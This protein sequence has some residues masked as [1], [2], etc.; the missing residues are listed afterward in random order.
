MSAGKR[1]IA[2]MLTFVMLFGMIPASAF[3]A[4]SGERLYVSN[5]GSGDGDGSEANPYDFYT[6]YQSASDGDTLFFLDDITLTSVESGRMDRNMEIYIDG[7]NHEL[8][9]A[10]QS[11]SH[12]GILDLSRGQITIC[13]LTIVGKK[14]TSQNL[15]CIYVDGADV[16]LSNVNL[17]NASMNGGGGAG[18]YINSGN[19]VL[20]GSEISNCESTGDD[21]AAIVI[22][23][24][25][26][27]SIE[28]TV[29]SDCIASDTDGSAVY[30]TGALTLA[31][32]TVIQNNDCFGV[33][34]QNS[35]NAVVSGNVL[36]TENETSNVYLQTGAT[37]DVSSP[38]TGRIGLTVEDARYYR[39]VS[40]PAPSIADTDE[41]AFVYD[42]NFYD[43]R[44][45]IY[46]GEEGLY[47][48]HHSVD[49]TYDGTDKEK[50]TDIQG[51]DINGETVSYPDETSVDEDLVLEV[52]T[53]DDLYRLP[54]E[55]VITVGGNSLTEGEDYNWDRETGIITVNQ[56]SLTGEVNISV[57]SEVWYDLKIQ[58]A[59]LNFSL[60][61]SVSGTEEMVG[62]HCSE[63]KTGTQV[64]GTVSSADSNLPIEG[65]TVTLYEDYH[66]S[67]VAGTTTTDENGFYIFRD[68][69]VNKSYVAVVSYE[70]NTRVVAS[71]QITIHITPHSGTN[72]PESVL[73]DGAM[74]QISY[75]N[76]IFIGTN[77]KQDTTLTLSSN[78][79]GHI[80]HFDT[81]GGDGVQPQDIS[82]V[83]NQT[84]FPALPETSRTG[85][86]FDG[87]YTEPIGGNLIEGGMTYEFT[88][89]VTLYAHWT[90]NGDIQYIVRHYA[91]Y[92]PD[93]VNEVASAGNVEDRRHVAAK[94][95]YLF[96]EVEYYNGVADATGMDI[97]GLILQ[98]MDETASEWWSIE[99]FHIDENQNRESLS[100]TGV[101]VNPDGSSVYNIYYDR[102][103]YTVTLPYGSA[104][105]ASSD[106]SNTVE[107]VYGTP[108]GDQVLESDVLPSLPGYDFEGWLDPDQQASEGNTLVQ[109][110]DLFKWT[111]DIKLEPVYT[112]R[113]D[114]EV[115]VHYLMQDLERGEDGRF[116]VKGT[117]T[118][119]DDSKAEFYTSDGTKIENYMITGTTDQDKIVAPA[120]VEGFHFV[121]YTTLQQGR[122]VYIPAKEGTA[123]IYPENGILN[124]YYDRNSVTV[125][126]D[127]AGG[128][129]GN[130]SSTGRVYYGGD[131]QGA[132]PTQPTRTGYDFDA[133]IDQAHKEVSENSDASDYTKDSEVTSL[134]LAATWMARTYT[135][136]YVIG[137]GDNVQFHPT[138]SSVAVP[139]GNGAYTDAGV[140]YGEVVGN[141]PTASRTGYTFDGWYTEPNGQG[142][143]ITPDTIVSA[144][145]LIIEGPDAGAEQESTR[146]LY[147][148]F[149]PNEYTVTFCPG[150]TVNT[151]IQGSVNPTEK[152]VRYDSIYGTLPIPTLTGYK[153]DGWYTSPVFEEDTEVT[154]NTVYK[155][156][157]DSNLYA[158]WTA[159]TY[160][161]YYDL[162][163]ED[164]GSTKGSLVDLNIQYGDQQYDTTML[165]EILGVK[166]VR[167]GYTHLGWSRTG[168][169]D[170][171]TIEDINNV[172]ED[173]VLYAIWQPNKYQITLAVNL[174]KE[175]A[176]EQLSYVFDAYYQESSNPS[177]KLPPAVEVAKQHG[178]ENLAALLQDY[179]FTGWKDTEGNRYTMIP[180]TEISEGKHA[181]S[182]RYTCPQNFSLTAELHP[183]L[184]FLKG[185]DETWGENIPEGIDD[186]EDSIRESTDDINQEGMPT[187]EKED[188]TFGGW[189]DEN[190]TIF[191]EKEELTE[192]TEPSDLTPVFY[193]NITFD[194]N[195]GQVERQ[196]TL[197]LSTQDLKNMHSLPSAA[198]VGRTFLG[199]YTE[200]SDGHNID[201]AFL[202]EATDPITVYAHYR[203]N[204]SGGGGNSSGGGGGGGHTPDEPDKY[205]IHVPD[206][207]HGTA[208]SDKDEAEEGEEV[209][210]DVTPDPG[211][212]IEDVTVTDP[213]DQEIDTEKTENGDYVFKMPGS[214]VTVNV[215]YRSLI[216]YYLNTE[217]HMAYMQGYPDHSFAPLADMTR[218][219]AAQMIYNL[220]LDRNHGSKVVSFT[221]VAE[222]AW[223]AEA[224][225]TL[226]SKGI[227]KGYRSD[228]FAPDHTI[229]RAEFAAMCVRFIGNADRSVYQDSFIDV[230]TEDWFYDVVQSAQAYGWIT[231]YEDGTFR[232]NANISR[233][234]VTSLMNEML[235]RTGDTV[236]I[237]AHEEELVSF[238]DLFTDTWYYID[239]CEST[240]AHDYTFENGRE[241]AWTALK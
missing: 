55:I 65:L 169:G 188:Y 181:N 141:M 231:G 7:N 210:I 26:S 153:F 224:V 147:A 94:E 235:D 182:I 201:L 25:G 1:L 236:Y 173:T 142:I 225:I 100:D 4:P 237:S 34:I 70:L 139:D 92:A 105:T 64:S 111:E 220:L 36:V 158:K 144:E 152:Q 211:Y 195:G 223:Y 123:Y 33:F 164:G 86:T 51:T 83:E 178:A 197:I 146:I 108:Y 159:E 156:P 121:G 79:N 122:S 191:E 50:L 234:E 127:L 165:D 155:I 60:T 41:D 38:V 5:L 219:E 82:V 177:S 163:D 184:T 202:Q 196:D 215:T 167:P 90:P 73:I 76:G 241:T 137:D 221:D 129:N 31:N 61:A 75:E 45:M 124:L 200:A 171:L 21:G 46:Q 16:T 84:T 71:D 109:P 161:Y 172:A 68:L 23:S 74:D 93:G 81:N 238:T 230:S 216:S 180:G 187:V 207:E 96:E 54:E 128:T 170:I 183:Y 154:E 222:D 150:Q 143:E 132:F 49:I 106:Q 39:L 140:T 217:D 168:D 226:A 130:D 148:Y 44:H 42:G 116:V 52:T 72:L 66:A 239:I 120:T 69:D 89:D 78:Q 135:P 47:L 9:Y 98:D 203:T 59:G 192:I 176:T 104:G 174:N 228:I 13:N 99:G 162:N 27:C 213:D 107:A 185:E 20:T 199:W 77:T 113:T 112:A 24:A 22:N 15:R 63:I 193:P 179:K 37:L 206:D 35:S 95:Y 102:N 138:T 149:T 166:A 233:A 229:T 3:A 91:E 198:Y 32:G 28:N 212:E 6:A 145:N 205:P 56:E 126:Y 134:T 157:S 85:Y 58:A 214:E 30:A 240:N 227:L 88:S 10:D 114:T 194:A 67:Q 87:W 204:G 53:D 40:S 43:I 209:I 131:F 80:I 125:A 118:D 57:Q 218:A 8:T 103:R 208:E 2:I 62:Y 29:I 12:Q 11:A 19:V 14:D 133:W 18:L 110:D 190:G 151:G 189:Q 115:A 160:R 186:T 48:W 175:V 17:Q 101:T 117:Y 232:P 97:S 136:S 119:V